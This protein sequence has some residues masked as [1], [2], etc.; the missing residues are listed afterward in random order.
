MHVHRD[1]GAF[2]SQ[3]FVTDLE[4]LVDRMRDEVG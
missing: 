2:E 3:T 1:V 4:N